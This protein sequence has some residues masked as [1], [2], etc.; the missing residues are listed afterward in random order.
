MRGLP[1]YGVL[2]EFRRA[3]REI[4]KDQARLAVWQPI[5][6]KYHP[7]FLSE[8]ENAIRWSNE[9]VLD[10]LQKNM[11][12][13][14][15]EAKAKATKIVKALTAYRGNKGHAR[16]L[17][18]E[19]CES[20][21]LKVEQIEEDQ[22]FQD[23]LLTVHHCYMH[24][25]MNTPAFKMIENHRGVAFVKQDFQGMIELMPRRAG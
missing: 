2:E 18:F 6:A 23:L 19:D 16:H 3:V 9:F 20:I 21:G 1:A 8:C 13:D 17:H 15:Q 14:A 22:E 12:K 25:L 5:I 10:Q 11:F 24:A 7:T 4:K